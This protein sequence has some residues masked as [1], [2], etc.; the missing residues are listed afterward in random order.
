MIVAKLLIIFGK[1]PS[2]VVT[3]KVALCYNPSTCSLCAI[4][5]LP[6]AQSTPAVNVNNCVCASVWVAV[7][8]NILVVVGHWLPIFRVRV[9][10]AL[11]KRAG[12]L[13]ALFQEIII[14]IIGH[15]K[16]SSASVRLEELFA[17]CWIVG[18]YTSVHYLPSGACARPLLH[19]HAFL[20]SFL[21]L[22]PHTFL[23]T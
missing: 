18:E 20:F 10:R 17:L 7:S 14:N 16:F 2:F 11:V 12:L 5:L 4:F 15:S 6:T 22:Q 8:Y 1:Y 19:P 3:F 13:S 21:L 9:V 23:Y